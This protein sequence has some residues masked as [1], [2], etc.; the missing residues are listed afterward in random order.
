M[1]PIRDRRGRTIA[2][3]GR[4]L[5]TEQPKYLNSPETPLFRKGEGVYGVAEARDAIRT[6]DR[7]VLVEGYMDALVLVQEGIPY[8]VAT[9]GTALTAAQLRLLRPLGGEQLAVFVF[10]DGDRAGRQAALRAFGVCAEAGVWGR[11]AFLPEG[12]DPDSYTRQHGAAATLALLDAAPSLVDFYFDTPLPPGASCR[13]ARA[14]P[15]TCSRILAQVRRRPA[16]RAAGAAGGGAAG[17]ERGAS[18]A[19]RTARPRRAPA[20]VP[21]RAAARVELA[22]AR[23]ACWSSSWPAIAPW[24]APGGGRRAGAFQQPPICATPAN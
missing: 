4:T 15:T 16:V 5:G 24:R 22:G 3:G 8:A 6:A 9:L 19:A 10:F 20:P 1:F 13:S 14:S 18:S 11:A 7:A 2:F 21:C 17:A 23:N 12:F